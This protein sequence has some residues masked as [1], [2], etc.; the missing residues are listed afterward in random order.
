MNSAACE[1]ASKKRAIFAAEAGAAEAA[2]LKD[3][4]AR[5]GSTRSVPTRKTHVDNRDRV[6]IASSP[7][8]LVPRRD[9]RKAARL[10]LPDADASLS[11]S[12]F[13]MNDSRTD[14]WPAGP[15]PRRRA[16]RI[17]LFESRE[18]NRT[19]IGS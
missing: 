8:F 16:G 1:G 13:P 17:D 10:R 4:A 3:R 15:P 6:T 2:L 9:Q 5:V 7:R 11:F 18:R 19:A 12:N 14:A